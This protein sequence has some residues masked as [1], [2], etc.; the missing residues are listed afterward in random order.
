MDLINS[1][2][3][4]PCSRRELLRRSAGAAAGVTLAAALPGCLQPK[5]SRGDKKPPW[6]RLSTSSVHFRSLPLEQACAR[7]AELGYEAIDLWPAHFKCPHLDE[8]EAMGAD[9]LQALLAR[10]RLGLSAFTVYHVGFAKHA[11]LLG[12]LGGGVAIR[13]SKYGKFDASNLVPE[14]KAFLESLKPQIELAEANR[15]YL[16]IENHRNSLL[17]SLDSFKAFVD[18]NTHP[19]VGI[20][21]APFHLQNDKEPVE[22]AIEIAGR[23]ILFFYAWQFGQ[24]MDELPGIGPADF[25][26]WLATLKGTGYPGYV[27]TFTHHDAPPDEMAPAL[28]RARDYV[29]GCTADLPG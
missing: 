15:S 8:A 29:R 3:E 7:V 1:R 25:K 21:L 4:S 22:P 27:N 20:A 24:G 13:D 11:A 10:H 9:A 16:A 26:P 23:Q 28:A 6:P 14:M 17:A 19:R 2:T 12:R 5:A 18:L